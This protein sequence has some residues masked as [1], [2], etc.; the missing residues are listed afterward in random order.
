MSEKPFI[1][2]GIEF[3]YLYECEVTSGEWAAL[4]LFG[5]LQLILIWGKAS[6]RKISEK[7]HWVLK[8][9]THPV[10]F[11]WGRG[12]LVGGQWQN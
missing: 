7:I 8:L 3:E 12:D 4:E 1:F 6:M 2:S 5:R 9:T 10:H 11:S